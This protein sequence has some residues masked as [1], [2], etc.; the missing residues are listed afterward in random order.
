[1]TTPR[2]LIM[3]SLQDVGAVGQGE[4]PA[5]AETNDA[6]TRLNFM[7]AQWQRKRWLIWHLIDYNTGISTGAQSYTIGPG[8]NISSPVRPDK[9]ESAFVRQV[10]PSQPN[11]IDYPLE[12]LQSREDYSRIALKSLVSFP[13]YLFYD[14]AYPLGILYP[15]PVPQA[16]LYTLFIQVKEILAQFTSLDQT[17]N[18]PNEYFAAIEYN[19]AMRLYPKYGFD[20]DPNIK[21]L[22][23]DALNV[24]RVEN[25]QVARMQMPQELVRPGIYNP[26]SDQIR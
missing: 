25:T 13:S 16:N 19:L 4:T 1:M 23:K 6:F 17:L 12:I 24:L 8:G 26:Y 22:A 7:L 10:V 18:I 3:L 21:A 14:S 20:V 9:I 2:D 15:W 5:A 11:Q